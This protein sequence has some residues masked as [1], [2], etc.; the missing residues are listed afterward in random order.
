MRPTRSDYVGAKGEVGNEVAVHHIPLDAIDA[1]VSQTAALLSEVGEVGGKDGG[2][3]FDPACHV[4][5]LGDWNRNAY[6]A[7]VTSEP[8]LTEIE[9]RVIRPANGGAGVGQDAHGRTTFCEGALPGER[10]RVGLTQEKKRF[11]RGI[12]TEVLEPA[13]DRIYAQCPTHHVGC[14]GCDMA[15]G[16]DDIQRTVKAHV[17]RD[18]LSRIGRVDPETIERSWL[19]FTEPAKPGWYRT[20]ARLAVARDRIGYRAARSH[21]VVDVTACGVVHPLVEE[22]VLDGRFPKESGP[23][24]MIRASHATGERMVIVDGSTN[25]VSVPA[26]VTLVSQAQIDAGADISIVEDAGGRSFVI[27]AGSFFQAGPTVATDLVAAVSAA[28]GDL[29]GRAVVDAYSGV[30]LF[31]GTVA[32]ASNSLTAVELSSSSIRDARRNL[33][34]QRLSGQRIDIVE[35]AV[36]DW[37]ATPAEVVI[38]DPSRAGLG[39]EGVE[40]LLRCRAER[41]ILVSCDTGSFGRDAGL[42]RNAGYELDSVRLVDAFRDTSHVE[43]IA[44]FT[45]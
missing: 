42:L 27:S 24:V 35:S 18:A 16:N 7:M 45:R 29:T 19:G 40:S 25:G 32:A 31:A 43:T 17:V 26:D 34:D 37:D 44:A 1:S 3:N 14:G 39:A 11:A 21:D 41:F 6:I 5:N 12:V 22:V 15:H 20:T 38:A 30:G 8:A 33:E 13:D 4:S 10:V 28:A 36:E 23:E 2:H 9:V